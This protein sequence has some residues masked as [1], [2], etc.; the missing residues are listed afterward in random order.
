LYK[1]DYKI[2]NGTD[3]V[4]APICEKYTEDR[5]QLSVLDGIIKYV[6]IIIN[7]VLRMVIIKII[8]KVGL[9]T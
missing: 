6:I 2:K 9:D 1:Q 7:T 8:D 5:L 4:E 3:I